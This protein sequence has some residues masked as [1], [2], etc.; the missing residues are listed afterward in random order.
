MI[1]IEKIV[2]LMS[3]VLKEMV[4]LGGKLMFAVSVGAF[5]DEVVNVISIDRVA[6]QFIVTPPDITGEEQPLLGAVLLNIEYDLGGSENVSRINEGE[7]HTISDWYGAVVANVHELSD[8]VLGINLRIDGLNFGFSAFLATPVEPFCVLGLDACRIN[9]H[10]LAEI[11]GG[12]GGVNI[13][14]EALLAEIGEIP[15]M[16]DVGVREHDAVD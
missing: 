12:K 8:T 9:Q 5:H 14:G 6:E 4:G 11:S 10:D 15:G 13:P 16:V 7:R 2:I 3:V 1:Q